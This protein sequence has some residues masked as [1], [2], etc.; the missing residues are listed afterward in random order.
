MWNKAK[1][2]DWLS[3]VLSLHPITNSTTNH[4]YWQKIQQR[5][6]TFFIVFDILYVYI[7]NTLFLAQTHIFPSYQFLFSVSFLLNFS[8][9]FGVLL[10]ELMTLG[11]ICKPSAYID[12]E[13]KCKNLWS[14][15]VTIILTWSQYPQIYDVERADQNK[16]RLCT[17]SWIAWFL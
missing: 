8:W 6:F 11:K 7:I 3:H 14:I 9:S 1:F 15:R 10:W 12:K 17:T 4:H 2:R 13:G 16:S 5:Q